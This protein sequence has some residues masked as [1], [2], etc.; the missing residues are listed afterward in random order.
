MIIDYRRDDK[1]FVRQGHDKSVVNI[2]SNHFTNEP[3]D[4]VSLYFSGEGKI[5]FPKPHLLQ[6]H[7]PRK[8]GIDLID[9]LLGSYQPMI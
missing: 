6:I 8:G 3:D 4:K 2:A 7:N 9:R 1:M 5:N